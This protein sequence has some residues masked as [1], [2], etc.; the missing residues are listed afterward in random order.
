M[1][2]VVGLVTATGVLTAA[3]LGALFARKT[4]ERDWLRQKR[5]DAYLELL[6]L[7]K[8]INTSFAV[9]QRVSKFRAASALQHGHDFEGVED[10]WY[11]HQTELEHLE[12]RIELLGGKLGDLYRDRA[13]DLII[14]MTDAIE[15][16]DITEDD[17]NALVMR[18]HDL[19]D[20][21][22]KIARQDLGVKSTKK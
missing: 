17:W 12:L 14:D 21:L 6:D 7:L 10:A 9:G 15:A 13:N 18:A 16:E 19:I 22:V 11:H 2:I 20:D 5:A 1:E 3:F 4:S 8:E